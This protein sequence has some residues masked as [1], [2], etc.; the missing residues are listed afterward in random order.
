MND[1]RIHPT[2][3]PEPEDDPRRQ[4]SATVFCRRCCLL[5]RGARLGVTETATEPC[6]P[7]RALPTGGS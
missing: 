4:R 5:L 7:A 3:E 2:H 6:R 1:R